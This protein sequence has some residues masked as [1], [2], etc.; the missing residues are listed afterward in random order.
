[1]PDPFFR[2]IPALC[3]GLDSRTPAVKPRGQ[4]VLKQLR[5]V[6]MTHQSITT[7]QSLLRPIPTEEFLLRN[8]SFFP[9]SFP[10]NRGTPVDEQRKTIIRYRGKITKYGAVCVDRVCVIDW[11]ATT[12]LFLFHCTRS[13]SVGFPESTT[14]LYSPEDPRN[15]RHRSMDR[16]GRETGHCTR[17]LRDSVLVG[18]RTRRNAAV[19]RQRNARVRRAGARANLASWKEPRCC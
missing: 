3:S 15:E 13:A 6:L 8:F 11:S 9:P 7:G 19:V 16:V 10:N 12:P 17:I 5:P 14:A 1:M 2:Y 4:C 18:T